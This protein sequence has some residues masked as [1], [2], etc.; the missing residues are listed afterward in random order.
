MIPSAWQ[1]A[2]LALAVY[3]IWRIL[4]LD[5]MPGLVSARNR[6]VGAEELAGIWTFK[7]PWLADLIQ[8]PWCLGWWISLFVAGWWFAEP[9]VVLVVAVPFALATLVGALGHLLN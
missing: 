8:C 5:D 4:G 9:H 3:R 1:L 6:L 7:R 2:L